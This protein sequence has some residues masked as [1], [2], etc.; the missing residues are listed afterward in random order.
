M[1][2]VKLDVSKT[3]RGVRTKSYGMISLI[4]EPVSLKDELKNDLVRMADIVIECNESGLSI[5]K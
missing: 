2:I 5:V 1:V 3:G 4:I